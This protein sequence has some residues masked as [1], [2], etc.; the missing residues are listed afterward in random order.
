MITT[1]LVYW[2]VALRLK[3]VTKAVILFVKYFTSPSMQT[4]RKAIGSPFIVKFIRYF[5]SINIG[6]ILFLS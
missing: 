5:E 2:Y 1:Y 6:K 4:Y 3:I